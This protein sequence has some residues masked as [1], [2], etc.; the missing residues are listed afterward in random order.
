MAPPD[1]GSEFA[2]N[3]LVH[4]LS[5]FFLPHLACRRCL[6]VFLVSKLPPARHGPPACTQP[7]IMKQ[8]GTGEVLR[9][10]AVQPNVLRFV[11]RG[12]Q[13]RGGDTDGQKAWSA[14]W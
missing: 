3:T 10:I 8:R 5:P 12:G 7:D 6:E 9:V 2:L 1:V 14:S 11:H 13:A 4:L